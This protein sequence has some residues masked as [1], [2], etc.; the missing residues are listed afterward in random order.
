M[1]GE[2][3]L[4]VVVMPVY[5]VVP[6]LL[7]AAMAG[8][9]CFVTMRVRRRLDC[10]AAMF[11]LLNVVEAAGR[12]ARWTWSLYRALDAF[13]CE[14]RNLMTAPRPAAQIAAMIPKREEP[15]PDRLGTRERAALS[16]LGN[17][18]AVLPDGACRA[19]REGAG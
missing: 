9:W 11:L 18:V 4:E 15:A 13:A 12:A 17:S 1:K 7:V 16:H 6:L 2:E 10:S 3:G 5:L 8:G 19:A 14:W